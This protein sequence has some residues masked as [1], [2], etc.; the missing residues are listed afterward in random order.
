MN[1]IIAHREN[2][3]CISSNEIDKIQNQPIYEVNKEEFVIEFSKLIKKPNRINE[4]KKNTGLY[5]EKK[6]NHF[7]N[8]MTEILSLN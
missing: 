1:E 6:R 4:M 8:T 3:I 2:G 7:I 5:I